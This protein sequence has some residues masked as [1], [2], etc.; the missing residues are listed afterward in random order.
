MV[1]VAENIKEEKRPTG[2]SSADYPSELTEREEKTNRYN[3]HLALGKN[4]EKNCSQIML[5]IISRLYN[6]KAKKSLLIFAPR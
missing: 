6:L 1:A 2:C 3:T 5:L 4:N